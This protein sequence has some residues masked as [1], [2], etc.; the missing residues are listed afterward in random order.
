MIRQSKVK[1]LRNKNDKYLT[2]PSVIQQLLDYK[3]DIPK[4]ASILEPCCSPEKIIINTLEKNGFSNLSYNIYD[5]NKPETNFLLFD[6]SNKY[7]Y[8]IT[9]TPY[10]RV[11]IDFIA[12]MKKVATKQVIALYNF[13]TLTG[14]NN[15]NKIWKDDTYKL[16]EI[17]ILVRPCWLKETAREDGKYKTGI[18]G[19]AWFVW[20]NGYTGEP[21]LRH[22]DNSRFVL[23]KKDD[24]IN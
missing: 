18:N 10:G 23:S 11:A 1:E 4:N 17:Y 12:K 8:I 16:K 24:I 2:P 3:K 15:Y 21:I 13:N 20:E 6:E 9:N 5:E 19:Y 7:D 22:I 14:T